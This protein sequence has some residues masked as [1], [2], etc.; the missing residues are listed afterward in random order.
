MENKAA[1][2]KDWLLIVVPFIP[3]TANNCY[4]TIW[5]RRM[6]VLTAEATAFKRRVAAEVVPKYLPQISALDRKAVY[7]IYYRFFFEKDNV[8]TKTFGMKN[9]A[10]SQYKKMDLENRLKLLTDVLATSIG[11]DDSQFFAGSQEKWSCD[12]VGGVPQVH[13]YIRK[14]ELSEFGF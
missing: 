2:N 14:A 13:A 10:D 1:I 8:M 4:K 11:I 7:H 6:R 9:G 5:A 12:V 3:P